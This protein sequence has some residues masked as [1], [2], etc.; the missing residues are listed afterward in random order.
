[1]KGNEGFNPRQK[2]E[3]EDI[4]NSVLLK[5]R[6]DLK[7]KIELVKELLKSNTLAAGPNEIIAKETA[8]SHSKKKLENKARRKSNNSSKKFQYIKEDTTNPILLQ[9]LED[10]ADKDSIL[11]AIKLITREVK[12]RVT[13]SLNT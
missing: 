11:K 1:M 13:N 4:I 2:K 12:R 10:V 7:G 5:F 8:S 3:I 6:N 9:N